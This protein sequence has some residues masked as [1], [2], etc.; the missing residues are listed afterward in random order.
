MEPGESGP[1]TL[2]KLPVFSTFTLVQLGSLVQKLPYSREETRRSVPGLL[3]GS[4]AGVASPTFCSRSEGGVL[5]I[6]ALESFFLMCPTMG[7]H[8]ALL[9][10]LNQL[11][12]YVP[13]WETLEYCFLSR[14][15]FPWNLCF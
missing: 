12:L 7:L 14:Y 3:G 9:G 6:P 11:P 10:L 8:F 5:P 1:L 15:H 4:G 13:C 2:F